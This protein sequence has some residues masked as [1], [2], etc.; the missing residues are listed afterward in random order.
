MGLAAVPRVI[1]LLPT[2]LQTSEAARL[3]IIVAIALGMGWLAV[4]R[5]VLKRATWTLLPLMIS[6][7][8]TCIG[9]A[10]GFVLYQ[11]LRSS[12]DLVRVNS[13]LSV[14]TLWTFEGSRELGAAGAIAYY[15]N[16]NKASNKAPN[17]SGWTTTN[18]TAYRIVMVLADGGKNRLPP[19]FPG[20][21]P[22]YLIDRLQLQAYWDSDRPVVFL[23]D[24]LR[25][26]NDPS[27]PITLNLPQGATE[28][29]MIS[30][31]RRLYLN[32]AARKLASKKCRQ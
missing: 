26:P 16:Q 6:S 10:R 8:I 1:T 31:Q 7:I 32:Q 19:R 5:G 30:G 21:F 25:Q 9:I 11:E 28:P 23:T 24:L 14:D 17:I 13:C 27:D 12:K 18:D 15:L 3:I 4:G 22:P 20:S 2:V 29:Y